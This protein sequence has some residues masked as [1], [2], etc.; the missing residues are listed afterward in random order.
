MVVQP[1]IPQYC[2]VLFIGRD[3]GVKEDAAGKPLLPSAP[4]GGLLRRLIKEVGI[5]DSVCGFDNVVHCHTPG[6]RGPTMIE[7]DKCRVW[8][9]RVHKAVQPEIVVLL[10]QEALE[11]YFNGTFYNPKKPLN[12]LQDV[13]NTVLYTPDGTK[14]IPIYHPSSALRNGDSRRK[15]IAGLRVVA[16]EL[17]IVTSEPRYVRIL[18]GSIPCKTTVAVDAEWSRSGDILGLGFAHRRED[19]KIQ[20]AFLPHAYRWVLKVIGRSHNAVVGHNIQADMRALSL[21]PE[22][23]DGWDIHDTMVMAQVLGRSQTLGS[24]GL[25]ELALADL[26]LS[27]STLNELGLPEDLAPE[28]LAD[29]CIKDCVATLLLY[30]KYKEELD[31]MGK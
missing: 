11:A 28:V 20:G 15:L 25:K 2:R 19:G 17:G 10:G 16:Q 21:S 29:Y 18:G 12:K 3:G 7:V 9:E 13:A 6:N 23:I 1:E 14:V 27:W 22:N 4:A 8:V 30:E 5:P 24:V 31:G 26:G